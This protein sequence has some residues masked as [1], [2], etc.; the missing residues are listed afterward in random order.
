MID[1]RASIVGWGRGAPAAAGGAAVASRAF[2][3]TGNSDATATITMLQMKPKRRSKLT[4][5]RA[6]IVTTI[7]SFASHDFCSKTFPLDDYP[8]HFPSVSAGGTQILTPR[9]L[10]NE[11]NA[12][13][14]AH[15]AGFGGR[16]RT[17]AELV[18]TASNTQRCDAVAGTSVLLFAPHLVR[19][20]SAVA[21]NVEF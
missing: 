18:A 11:K 3:L 13:R 6:S 8:R 15:A 19:N 14:S 7:I 5:E 10:R 16:E 1:S 9:S 4:V 21:A 2:A 20:A 17:V 12:Q